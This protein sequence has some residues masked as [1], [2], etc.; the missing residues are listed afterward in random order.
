MSFFRKHWIPPGTLLF[1][2][3]AHAASWALIFFAAWSGRFDDPL[4]RFGWIHTVALGWITMAALGILLH[5]LPN[6][7]DV[8]WRGQTIARWTLPVY[9][10]GVVLLV[11]GFIANA[12]VLGVAGSVLFA[13]L[14]VYLITAFLTLGAAMRGDRVQ[15]AVARA[16][17]IT[18][19]VLLLTA[20]MGFA[21]AFM[22]YGRAFWPW[23]PALPPAHGNLGMLGWISLLIFGVSM[24]TFK[25]ITGNRTRFPIVHMIAGSLGLLG[26]A[27]IAAGISWSGGVLF[28]L[29]ALAYVV[30]TFDILRR[31]TNRHRPPQAFITASVIWLLVALAA[32]CG[33]LLGKPWQGLYGFLL[34]A[35]WAGQMVNA[36]LHHIGIR[37]VSTVFRGEEDETEPRELLEPRLSW[38]AFSSFQAAIV[39]VAIALLNDAPGIAARGAVFGCTA[40]IA[41]TANVIVA[42][43]RAST[44]PRIIRL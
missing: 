25:P 23:V 2:Q 41:M 22:L 30:D 5:A 44:P 20:F 7:V 12:G 16:F 36:H 42:V 10:A 33:V 17:I 31:S 14:A 6:F 13:A 19:F 40:W 8:P 39:I 26:I 9:A 4:F 37:L 1:A 15:R 21:L 43:I 38:L 11:Y 34:L 24:R 3:L 28:V 18:F 35:G 27:L 32:G 29:A